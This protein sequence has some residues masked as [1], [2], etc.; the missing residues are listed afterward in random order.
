ME[1]T[2]PGAAHAGFCRPD[3]LVVSNGNFFQSTPYFLA[4]A[5]RKT[6]N[7]KYSIFEINKKNFHPLH[8]P[9]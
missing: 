4:H 2:R 8:L 7:G 3:P 9:P 1:Q 6:E 5:E